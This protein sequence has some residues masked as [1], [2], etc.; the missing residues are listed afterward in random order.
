MTRADLSARSVRSMLSRW[1]NFLKRS[2]P[3]IDIVDAP[4]RVV[5]SFDDLTFTA[6]IRPKAWSI[7]SIYLS[8]ADSPSSVFSPSATVIEPVCYPVTGGTEQICTVTINPAQLGGGVKYYQWH[9]DYQ[10]QSIS[11][12][13]ESLTLSRPE[14]PEALEVR[15]FSLNTQEDIKEFFRLAANHGWSFTGQ[16]VGSVGYFGTKCTISTS[17]AVGLFAEPNG[18]LPLGM[19][20]N[21]RCDFRLFA[22]E[23]FAEGWF[24]TGLSLYRVFGDQ[25]DI[26]VNSRQFPTNQP[27]IF[28]TL[29]KTV[30]GG[31][32]SNKIIAVID[33]IRL[34]GATTN[35]RDAFR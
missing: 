12:N 34:L 9:L 21:M 13:S 19:V 15:V 16:E 33:E 25:T 5:S 4:N 24:I 8:Y 17:G 28:I 18:L 27:D 23:P 35:W 1:L 2:T 29:A 22:W 32:D 14:P 3:Q 30:I 20:G 26:V 10:S 6:R 7:S 11:I 31:S